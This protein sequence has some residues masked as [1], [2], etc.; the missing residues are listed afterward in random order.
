MLT[1]FVLRDK[2]DDE[3]DVLER[4][5]VRILGD[6]LSLIGVEFHGDAGREPVAL[7]E[8]R[9]PAVVHH[10]HLYV[11]LALETLVFV[12]RLQRAAQPHESQHQ[13]S[14]AHVLLVALL[15]AERHFHLALLVL[16][17][18]F[19]KNT[20]RIFSTRNVCERDYTNRIC[21]AVVIN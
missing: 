16:P 19:F 15:L 4:A 14:V 3:A 21:H 11:H 1:N 12:H 17:L 13:P 6:D 5:F 18:K 7:P 20:N 9:H 2:L 8:M 10:R